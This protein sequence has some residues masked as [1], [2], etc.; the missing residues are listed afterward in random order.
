MGFPATSSFFTKFSILFW[1]F[2]K[3][4]AL[5]NPK[6]T[7]PQK[8]PDHLPPLNS[9]F[10]KRNQTRKFQRFSYFSINYWLTTRKRREK[11]VEIKFSRSK[12]V[13][14]LIHTTYEGGRRTP[15]KSSPE[16]VFPNIPHCLKDLRSWIT[17]AK[18]IPWIQ[19]NN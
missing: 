2:H 8:N 11:L 16:T 7:P 15:W 12:W 19:F 14:K 9:S 3:F 1:I 10:K 4:F 6:P 17:L 18:W 13:T 5:Q